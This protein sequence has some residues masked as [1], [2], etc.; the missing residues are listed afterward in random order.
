MD[1]NEWE[2][3]CCRVIQEGFATLKAKIR[4]GEYYHEETTEEEKAAATTTE[5][6]ERLFLQKFRKR[7]EPYFKK[8]ADKEFKELDALSW[9]KSVV[10]FTYHGAKIPELSEAL[11]KA[12]TLAE[13]N[14]SPKGN[15]GITHRTIIRYGR[16]FPAV[17]YSISDAYE[18]TLVSALAFDEQ[19][20]GA[21]YTT[22]YVNVLESHLFR[23]QEK[24]PYRADTGSD[25]TQEH[26]MQ[27]S[28]REKTPLQV[29]INRESGDFYSAIKKAA[30]ALKPNAAR[31]IK[32]AE[33]RQEGRSLE[34]IGTGA[35]EHGENITKQRVKQLVE[36]G[37]EALRAG[38][39][40]LENNRKPETKK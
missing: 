30:L 16:Q 31:A 6:R 9:P 21:A 13:Y 7:I 17:E 26:I 23:L 22:F 20:G 18:P 25:S 19:G 40:A 29:L 14:I 27:S 38:A 11:E 4:N 3:E 37:L 12:K 1:K 32:I 2:A 24:E 28:S 36:K 39:E 5:A 10:L 35:G 34:D 8:I 15:G 33:E